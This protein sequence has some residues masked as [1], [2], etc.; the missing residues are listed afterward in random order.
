MENQTGIVLDLTKDGRAR[1]VARRSSACNHCKSS[2]KCCISAGPDRMEVLAVNRVRARPGDTV[3]LHMGTTGVVKG[4]SLLYGLPLVGLMSGAFAGGALAPRLGLG[5]TSASVVFAL[6]GLALSI[7]IVKAVSTRLDSRGALVPVIERVVTKGAP[8]EQ[9][10]KRSGHGDP[11]G[12]NAR[13]FQE[14]RL[15]GGSLLPENAKGD[16]NRS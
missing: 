6:A 4:A 7:L 1:V 12:R 14:E 11:M 3:L 15:T 13:S 9:S 8:H 5:E 2:S 10:P 16:K